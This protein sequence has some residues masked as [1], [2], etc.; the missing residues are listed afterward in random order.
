VNVYLFNFKPKVQLVIAIRVVVGLSNNFC[1]WYGF[2]YISIGKAIL[3]WSLSPLFCAI[4]A[5]IFLKEKITYQSIGLI[6][7][8][9][10]GVYLLT[11]NKSDDPKVAS[12]ET[13]GY[14]LVVAS[15]FLYALLFVLLRTMSING[16][17]AFVSPLYFGTGVLIQNIIIFIFFPGAFHFSAYMDKAVN[18]LTLLLMM[19]G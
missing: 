5:A 17:H 9:I 12:N 2:Q 15:A 1:L 6:L 11:L 3:I 19:I 7:I 8:S 13:L 18:A 10:V 14:C 16:V 4:T